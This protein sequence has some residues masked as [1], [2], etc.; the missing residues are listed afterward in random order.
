MTSTII[1][2]IDANSEVFR[3][4][5]DADSGLLGYQVAHD[6]TKLAL[7][8]D[9]H[10]RAVA[11]LATLQDKFDSDLGVQQ[12]L[13]VEQW[14]AY[15]LGAEH[16]VIRGGTVDVLQ[17]DTL[18]NNF[19]RANTTVDE[20]LNAERAHALSAAETISAIRTIVVIT[21]TLA[22][23]V[24]T[25]VLGLRYSRSVGQPIEALRDTMT[26]QRDGD[27]G[28]HAREDQ[29]SPEIR[30]LAIDFNALAE[31]NRIAQQH[32]EDASARMASLVDLS[33]ALGQKL[34]LDALLIRIVSRHAKCSVPLRALGVL[35]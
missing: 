31:T 6:L 30:S 28:A 24:T 34:S 8:R 9:A 21:A 25:L 3:A 10:Q 2:A 15:A 19:R 32:V 11:A 23:L 18:F 4:M 16:A 7:Y 5:T 27:L 13:A 26:R 29:G 1:P 33:L 12:R 35:M 20:R 14:W 17:G 22:A